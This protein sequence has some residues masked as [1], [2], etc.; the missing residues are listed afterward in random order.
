MIRYYFDDAY[1]FRYALEIFHYYATCQLSCHAAARLIRA[2]YI[3][4]F[5][6]YAY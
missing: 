6:R 5:I 2:H 3:T 4:I 1:A